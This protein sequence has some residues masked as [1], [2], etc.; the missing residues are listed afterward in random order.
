MAFPPGFLDELRGRIS[1]PGL[2]S[3]Q[4]KLERR[5][6]EF[7]GLCPFHTEKTPS[8]YVVEDK[9]FFHCFGCGA[10]GD[11]IGFVMRADNLDFLEAVEKLAG[12]AGLAV[13]QSTPEEREKAQ[14]QKTL[15]ETLEAAA[16]FYEARLWSP[17]GSTARDYLRARGLDPDTI[18]RFRLGWAPDDR[19]SLR[20]ALA[21]DFGEALLV[22]T[23]LLH[24]PEEG[25]A[26][27]YFRNRV[28]FPIG[29]RAGR[30]I[31]F[32]GRVLADGQPKYLNSPE[33]P[34]F[35]KGRV[36]YGWSAARAAAADRR[37]AIVTEGYMDVIALHHAGFSSAVAP[38]GTAL[39]EYQLEELW[40]LGPEPIL[41]FDGDAAGQR[42]A[43]RAL[44]RA[45]PLLRP[46]RSLR[47]AD[48]PSGEDPDSLIRSA[49]RDI[50]E[51]V[52]AA[53]RPLSH[54]LWEI[55]LGAS[56]VDTPERRADLDHRL[57]ENVGLIVD[58]TV[59]N[60]YRRY[61]R[62]RLFESGRKRR[63]GASSSTPERFAR[64]V[65]FA[66]KVA[67]EFVREGPLSPPRPPDRVQR[68]LLFRILLQ[69]PSLLDEVAEEFATI[70]MP[71]P[72][73]DKLRREI[74]Q[75]E[76]LHPGLEASTLR[77]HLHTNGFAATVEAFIS[78]SVDSG[79]LIRR[80]ATDDARNEW[81]HVI[82]MLMGGQRSVLAEASNHLIDDVSVA[83][84]EHF[85]AARE[86]ALQ[87]NGG[88][89]ESI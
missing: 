59:R 77:Q 27:D 54:M 37:D 89:D 44:R 88:N 3:R 49:G 81:A 8:F 66:Q 39:T 24:R 43:A 80:S 67:T 51:Q 1:L 19:Q 73:L 72:D 31:A 33:S 30:I 79:F 85:L 2:V 65:A 68:E 52:L 50:F 35:Q 45:L 18:R 83:S 56:P 61:V 34:I 60:E 5:G 84:W 87:Q 71:E 17:A 58:A 57:M 4:V 23:G 38:L 70:E 7:A 12:E 25:E 10:H 40:R 78:P 86:R 16:A 9:N 48:L 82:E 75:I 22:E 76:A 11:A 6:R 42:A 53:A 36:L 15:L 29:D 55:E 69:W 64:N 20:R 13:P 47:F 32:G 62:D 26:F 28:M 21:A 41:C 63:A 46:G 74:L 14:R